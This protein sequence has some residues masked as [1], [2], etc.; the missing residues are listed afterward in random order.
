MANLVSLTEDLMELTLS[1]P[2]HRLAGPAA[3][4]AASIWLGPEW[5]AGAL[6]WAAHIAADRAV[7]YG[8]RD[9]RGFQRAA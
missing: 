9:A 5:L 1:V 7:G 6:G 3:L 8:L 4:A 2:V